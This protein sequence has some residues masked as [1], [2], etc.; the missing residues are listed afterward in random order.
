ML[1]KLL[2]VPHESPLASTAADVEY[3]KNNSKFSKTVLARSLDN[4]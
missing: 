2:K 4:H 3:H 1:Q